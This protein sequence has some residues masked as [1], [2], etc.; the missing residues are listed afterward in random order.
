MTSI[1]V[2]GRIRPGS[3][4]VPFET[5]GTGSI[6]RKVR[7]ADLPRFSDIDVCRAWMWAN[8]WLI[9]RRRISWEEEFTDL[10]R[11]EFLAGLGVDRRHTAPR[12]WDL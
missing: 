1:I 6:T 10:A 12:R 9:A 7:C 3:V 8:Q 5:L 4:F 2:N 11:D